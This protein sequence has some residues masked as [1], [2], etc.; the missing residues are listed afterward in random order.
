MF[1]FRSAGLLGA[2]IAG[3]IVAWLVLMAS[4]HH[5]PLL[6][7]LGVT[8]YVLGLRH[9]VDADHIAAIDGTTRKLLHEQQP[10][11]T[12]GFYFS[13][14]HSTIVFAL[15][16]GV[17]VLGVAIAPRL[18]LLQSAGM[19]VGTWISSAFLLLIAL[20]NVVVLAD[21]LRHPEAGADALPGG[22]LAR[23]LRPVLR[24]VRRSRDMYGVG[25]LF[26]LGFDSATE[27][28]LLGM[29]AASGAMGMPVIYLML[30]PCLFAAAM[31][32]VDT[33]EGLA[34]MR[35]YRWTQIRPRRRLIYNVGITVI[36]ILL[37][38]VVSVSEAV[39]ALAHQ[40]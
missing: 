21:I 9:A 23:L 35:A 22:F 14:G 2:L 37:A 31:S 18:P 1:N 17:A 30:L 24:A 38:L 3:N 27:I 16:L 12:V 10:A 40:A 20:A 13:I 6:L 34:V 28:A 8:A 36:T 15:S 33:A 39:A 5:F 32:L 4:A 19:V 26:G 25:L 7:P 29:S 11:E